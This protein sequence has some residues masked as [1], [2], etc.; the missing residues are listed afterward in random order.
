MGQALLSYISLGCLRVH[1]KPLWWVMPEKPVLREGLLRWKKTDN[2]F[3]LASKTCL[4]TMEYISRAG[5]SQA[6]I[7]CLQ[8]GGWQEVTVT[9]IQEISLINLLFWS[10][11]LGYYYDCT[12][13][14]SSAYHFKMFTASLC[15]LDWELFSVRLHN[16]LGDSKSGPHES[17]LEHLID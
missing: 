11:I 10:K 14:P 5:V 9:V 13:K 2:V 16:C 3:C 12:L 7:S 1:V 6:D 8:K 17:R 4:E 15:K